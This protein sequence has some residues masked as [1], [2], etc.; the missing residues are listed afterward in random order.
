MP[1]HLVHEHVPLDRLVILLQGRFLFHEQVYVLLGLQLYGLIA[2]VI[3]STAGAGAAS[4]L[5]LLLLLDAAGAAAGA[6]DPAP[7]IAIT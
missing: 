3:F 1:Q 6:P 2:L 7:T 4:S 5:L